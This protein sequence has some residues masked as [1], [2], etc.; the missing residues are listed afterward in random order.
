MV[1]E[2]EF[3]LPE[4]NSR[5]KSKLLAY[6]EQV[7]TTQQQ[8][9][10]PRG[11][12]IIHYTLQKKRKHIRMK[13]YP[14]DDRID[15]QSGAQ[16]FY[17]C[18]RED[19][20]RDEHG[21]FHC[22]LRYKFISKRIKPKPLADWDKHID[23][24]MAHIVAIAMNRYG[25]PIRLFTVNRWITSEIWYDCRHVPKFIKQFKM[26]KDDD[27]HWTT[28]DKW[29]EGMIQLFAPQIEWLHQK[30]D[31][32]IERHGQLNPDTNVYEDEQLEETSEIAIDLQSQIQWLLS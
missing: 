12:N 31:A 10:T 30:R 25:L 14:N 32:A 20:E 7:L 23:N 17:H 11:K 5:Q 21:H 6:A 15:Y 18:H 13:H 2:T 1:E 29:V 22:F 24:P 3:C 4:L 27:A 8:M 9:I 28:L 16:Y 19:I 26:S